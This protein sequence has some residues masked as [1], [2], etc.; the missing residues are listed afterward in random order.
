[1][2]YMKKKGV[3]S[4]LVS[5]IVCLTSVSSWTAFSAYLSLLL[6]RLTRGQ[7]LQCLSALALACDNLVRSGSAFIECVCLISASLGF[8]SSCHTT[9]LFP[10]LRVL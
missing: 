2:I 8:S 10:S 6:A 1:V 4:Y 9:G 7:K 5:S 3:R